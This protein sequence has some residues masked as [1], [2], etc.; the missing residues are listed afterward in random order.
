MAGIV[1]HR[2][3]G[4]EER[5]VFDIAFEG[6]D[7]VWCATS[8]GL[9]RYDGYWWER[10]G[11]EDGLPNDYVRSVCVT[12]PGKLWVGTD[13]GAVYLEDGSFRVAPEASGLAGKSIRRI[14]EDTDG[15][16]WFCCDQWPDRTSPGGLVG[17]RGGEWTHFGYDDG[18]PSQYVTD[19]VRDSRGR[20]FVLTNAGVAQ[21][22]GD[23]LIRPLEDAGLPAEH[24]WTLVERA[25]G[26]LQGLAWKKSFEWD[27]VNGW[28]MEPWE[29]EELA[30]P[31]LVVTRDGD[32]VTC[33]DWMEAQIVRLDGDELVPLSASF[34]GGSDG[35][36]VVVE[37]PD[38]AIWAGGGNLLV[39]A[40]RLLGEWRSYP[41]RGMPELR[42]ERG[43]VWF[44]DWYDPVEPVRVLDR[45]QWTPV[46]GARGLMSVQPAQGVFY[47][48]EEGFAVYREG[49]TAYHSL[50]D[51]GVRS[52]GRVL[53]DADGHLWATARSDQGLTVIQHDGEVWHNRAQGIVE[54]NTHLRDIEPHSTSGGLAPRLGAGVQPLQPAPPPSGRRGVAGLTV[55]G[56]PCHG[57]LPV[58]TSGGLALGLR[59]LWPLRLRARRRHGLGAN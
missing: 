28:R 50:A 16:V 32:L 21:F 30:H 43:R 6:D 40:Q 10:L 31:E 8:D 27:E 23:R 18:L 3:R 7:L 54:P 14:V 58:A 59:V 17:F 25:D 22:D 44:E 57:H 35:V 4:L 36:R 38:G 5:T 41:A 33:T 1:L 53:Y 42:D 51:M 52:V 19:F 9:Y 39:R 56:R 15:S 46:A 24:I 37:A 47:V 12:G 55:R 2:R 45:G 49:D 26:S 13:I 20:G 29:V 11:V 48:T 34:P